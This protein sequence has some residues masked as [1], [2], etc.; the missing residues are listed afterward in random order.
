[1][2]ASGQNLTFGVLNS[3]NSFDVFIRALEQN[4]VA[5]LLDQ[6]T[7]V[8][9]HGRPAEFLSGGEIPIAVASGLGTN[10]IEFRAFGTK[11][12]IVP[13]ILGGGEMILEVRAEV[14]EVA[15]DLSGDTGVPG[16]RVRRVNTGVKMRAGHTLALAGDYR[17]ITSTQNRG[18]PK[19]K[20]SPFIG[21]LFRQVVDEV[22]ETELV[23]LITP[24]FVSDVEPS[25]L[26]ADR[27][28]RLTTS[29]SNHELYVDGYT[30]VPRCTDDCPVTDSFGANGPSSSA[31]AMQGGYPQGGVDYQQNGMGY[32]SLNGQQQFFGPVG[33]ARQSAPDRHANSGFAWPTPT[34]NR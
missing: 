4:N 3:N 10:S 15:N 22:N 11:L 30:E 8:T 24:R 27:P 12:D 6:P 2:A 20:H 16:F 25:Q 26:P 33:A 19:L 1:M 17:E 7:I 14:S 34:R 28:G 18:I 9:T 21:P 13:L 32:P 5:K 29:P 23:F 31:Q